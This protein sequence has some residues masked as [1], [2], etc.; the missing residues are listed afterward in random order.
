MYEFKEIVN[1]KYGLKLKTYDDLYRWSIENIAEFW[2][3]TWW[4]TGI[5][6]EKGFEKVRNG[7]FLFCHEMV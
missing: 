4:F 6:V 1:K 3:E 5:R 2:E 7:W